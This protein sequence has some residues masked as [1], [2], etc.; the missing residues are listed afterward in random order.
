MRVLVTGCLGLLGQRLIRLAPPSIELIAV[1]IYPDPQFIDPKIY[2]RCDLT[3]RA[4]VDQLFEQAAPDCVIHTAAYTNVDKAEDERDWCWKINVSAVEYLSMAAKR[5]G[6]SLYHISTD[7]IFDGSNG[8]YREDSPAHPLGFYG[9][10]KW[11]AEKVLKRSDIPFTI[12]RTMVLYGISQNNRPDFVG[13]L[14]SQLGQNM[15]VNIVTDQIG[16]STLNDE[17]ALALW[18]LVQR[19]Y[20]GIVNLAGRE[21]MSRYEFAL[22]VAR[23]FS[24]DDSLIQPITTAQLGQQAPRPLQ[25]GL[26][27]DKAL[28]SLGLDLTDV[29]T[30]LT[31]Y[32]KLLEKTR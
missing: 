24:L 8:P 21:I 28:Y 9:M 29:K 15:S 3:Q 23:I 18:T 25:S 32:K 22:E 10:S 14:I 7:Y 12:A 26:V 2:Y 11:A 30:S 1:D 31:K 27:I 6:A 4:D 16:N 17:L 20:F 5:S 13:W 19:S